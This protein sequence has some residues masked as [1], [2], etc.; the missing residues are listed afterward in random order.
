[1]D[2]QR[3]VDKEEQLTQNLFSHEVPLREKGNEA[4]LSLKQKEAHAIVVNSLIWL[5]LESKGIHIEPSEFHSYFEGCAPVENLFDGIFIEKENIPSYC[6]R[7]HILFYNSSFS[8]NRNGTM[9]KKSKDNLIDSGSVYTLPEIA[10]SIVWRCLGNL[11]GEPAEIKVLDFACG[12]GRFYTQVVNFFNET[13]GIKPDTTIA[14]NVFA[15]DIDPI[16]VNICRLIA[17]SLCADPDKATLQTISSHIICRNALVRNVFYSDNALTHDDFN[18]LHEGHF[19]AV[20]SNPPYLVLKPNKRKMNAETVDRITEMSSYFKHSQDFH[21]SIEGML[22]LYQLSIEAIVSM[23]RTGG[24]VG[25][26]CPSTL[27]ADV[28]ATKLRKYLLKFHHVSHIKYFAEEANLF[29]NVIQATCIFHLTK[30]I[31]T[32]IISIENQNKEYCISLS[33]VV[34]LFGENFEIP[35][36]DKT[37]WD[38]LRIL[39]RLPKVKDSPTIRNKRGELDITLCEK[40]ITTTPTEYRL[41][42]GNMIS[43]QGIKDIN[44]EYVLP[45]FLTGKSSDFKQY[46]LKRRR[47]ICQQIS[48][49]SQRVRLRF[50]YCE[51][52]DI[53]A[54]SCNYISATDECLRKLNIILNSALLNWRFKVTSTNN[55]INNYEIDE[56][57]LVDLALVDE[58][59]QD[60]SGTQRDESICALYGLDK[61]QTHFILNTLK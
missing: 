18:G 53:L 59:L 61:E 42:R 14:N 57:P 55:H 41:V 19:D 24:E 2:Y 44:G 51:E 32:D 5:Y 23:T 10:H 50:V 25:I 47:L 52:N 60:I 15:V 12:T 8:Y 11:K 45:E 1:M 48:N 30:G 31:P 6:E 56:L 7:L 36:V 16:S 13:W 20:V 34:Q 58:S 17:I 54:N 40:F 3:I 4:L 26:I 33:D 21:Y 38:I 49:Q 29:D 43:S 35:S 22:N 27:F 9:R 46:D 39:N 28:S 37:E